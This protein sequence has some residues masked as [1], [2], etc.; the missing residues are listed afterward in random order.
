MQTAKPAFQLRLFSLG[1]YDEVMQLWK[2]TEGVGLN[3]SDERPAIAAFLERN[4][5]LSRVA[6]TPEGKIVG[7]L[8]CG[9]DGR[10]GYLHHLAVAPEY[11]RQGIGQA[12]VETC[13]GELKTLG[14]PKC[15]LFL[16][17]N[18]DSG[19]LF[20]KRRGWDARE[21]LVVVQKPT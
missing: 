17:S 20:W 9:H 4:Q 11:R 12:L 3:E 1:D 7:A 19:R 6:V 5:G 8:L 2:H 18:N 14:I 13:I 21:D 10:R 16:Y 15:N